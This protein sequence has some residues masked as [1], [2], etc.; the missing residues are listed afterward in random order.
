MRT[1]CVYVCIC[2][3]VCVCVRVRVCVCVCVREKTA[4]VQHSFQF[5]LLLKQQFRTRKTLGL[6]EARQ[7]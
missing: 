1:L 5:N 2:M 4:S 6:N 7:N 3:H